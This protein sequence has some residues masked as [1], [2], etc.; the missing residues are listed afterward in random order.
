MAATQAQAMARGCTTKV[1]L[2]ALA[3]ASNR[4][5]LRDLS[6]SSRPSPAAQLENAHLFLLTTHTTHTLTKA[7]T[8]AHTTSS[9]TRVWIQLRRRAHN[10]ARNEH[11]PVIGAAVRGK[12]VAGRSALRFG[13]G[14]RGRFRDALFRRLVAHVIQ[15]PLRACIAI[16]RRVFRRAAAS[17]STQYKSVAP[18][19]RRR[20]APGGVGKPSYRAR[21]RAPRRRFRRGPARRIEPR[22][23]IPRTRPFRSRGPRGRAP[24]SLN[25]VQ[26]QH[27]SG[28]SLASAHY[29]QA[30]RWCDLGGLVH[31]AFALGNSEPLATTVVWASP[32]SPVSALGL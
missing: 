20:R 29:F 32:S 28:A 27:A 11:D 18:R 23:S 22:R 5:A 7:R 2:A 21:A 24:R 6:S 12:E 1:R 3:L 9:A 25:R 8:I 15:S 13:A 19:R 4:V 16:A 31:G 10:R 14:A 30:Q 17:T 26:L